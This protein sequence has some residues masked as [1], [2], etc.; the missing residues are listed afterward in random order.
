MTGVQVPTDAV[1]TGY[2]HNPHT[3]KIDAALA[4]LR[5]EKTSVEGWQEIGVK[6]GII[7]EKKATAGDSSPIPTVRSRGTVK[8]MSPAALFATISPP[9]VRS[10]WDDRYVTGGLL[11]R[12]DRYTSKYYAV[13]KGAGFLVSERDVVGIQAIVVPEEGVQNGF[14]LVQTSVEGDPENSGRVRATI[15]C[16]GW[17]VVPRGEDLEIVYVMKMNPN[18]KIPSAMISKVVEGLPTIVAKVI[19]FIQSS[20]HPPYISTPSISSQLRTEMFDLKAKTH[21]IKLIAG[22][23]EEELAV[24]VDPKLFGGNWKVQVF[25][26]G[27]VSVGKKTGTSAAVHVPA[28]S[29]KVEIGITAA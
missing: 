27:N 7:M 16:A 11:E 12:Y 22:N 4:F 17:S 18:G 19:Q 14:E 10:H 26:D 2:V 8:N 20:G 28:G 6:D 23:Q 3:A 21:T 25:G 13:Q 1:P 24:A 5:A 29:G 15:T 9:S